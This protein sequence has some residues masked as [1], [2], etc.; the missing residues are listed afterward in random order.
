MYSI[1]KEDKMKIKQNPTGSAKN[2]TPKPVNVNSVE[3]TSVEV[4]SAEVTSAEIPSEKGTVEDLSIVTRNQVKS[5]I[6]YFRDMK[7]EIIDVMVEKVSNKKTG[8][9]RV[10]Y[11]LAFEKSYQVIVA[12]MVTVLT[13]IPYHKMFFM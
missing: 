6:E 8:F 2:Q 12:V 7:D 9:N 13:Q 5:I 4:T 10:L 1:Y 3:I 11:K